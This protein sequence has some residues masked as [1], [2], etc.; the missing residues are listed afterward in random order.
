MKTLAA[1]IPFAGSQL[2]DVRHVCAFFGSADEEYRV[3]LP[4]IRDGFARGDKAV[5]VVKP[6]ERGDHLRRLVA[7]H[8]SHLDTLVE[9]EA[10]VNDIWSRHDDAVICVYDLSQFGGDMVIDMIRTHPMVIVGG[11]LQQNP[12]YVPPEQFLRERR[13]RHVTPATASSAAV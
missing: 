6:D 3:L 2:G 8:R 4:F 9:F 10:R 11:I 13:Q 1:P 5:H 12:F 7:A